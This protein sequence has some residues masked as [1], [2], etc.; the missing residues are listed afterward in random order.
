[1][2]FPRF[3][4][5][6]LLAAGCDFL[7]SLDFFNCAHSSCHACILS[8]ICFLYA[9]SAEAASPSRSSRQFCLSSRLRSSIS[10]ACL[11][12]H[13]NTFTLAGRHL[14]QQQHHHRQGLLLAT[15]PGQ[16]SCLLWQLLAEHSQNSA[17]FFVF[18]KFTSLLYHSRYTDTSFVSMP[19]QSQLTITKQPRGAGAAGQQH[20]RIQHT[21]LTCYP[22]RM[23]LDLASRVSC[24]AGQ[25]SEQC[26]KLFAAV[27]TWWHRVPSASRS[28]PLLHG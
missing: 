11:Q 24:A 28:R 19:L 20:T 3:E 25:S 7:N 13:P 18:F 15:L 5:C 22:I 6:Q 27:E 9:S 14:V 10:A 21:F 2:A 1:M 26:R 8:A 12:H 16:P 17:F 23:G 4:E